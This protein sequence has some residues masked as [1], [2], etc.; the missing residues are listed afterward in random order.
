MNCARRPRVWRIRCAVVRARRCEP[1]VGETHDG[2]GHS[3]AYGMQPLEEHVRCDKRVAV[4][5]LYY[6]SECGCYSISRAWWMLPIVIVA[7][8]RCSTVSTV[9]SPMFMSFRQFKITRSC[10]PLQTPLTKMS[11]E[12]ARRRRRRRSQRV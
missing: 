4:A 2:S 5:R 1:K 9:V 3:V 12:E 10:W 6:N 8:L 7:C 11:T